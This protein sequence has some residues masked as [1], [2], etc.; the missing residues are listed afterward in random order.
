MISGTL[1]VFCTATGT[2]PLSM[3]LHSSSSVHRNKEN[4][5]INQT[6]NWGVGWG[7]SRCCQQAGGEHQKGLKH[8]IIKQII[9]QVLRGWLHPEALAAADK[10]ASPFFMFLGFS[11]LGSL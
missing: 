7:G 4:R 10:T 11:G 3:W 2:I 5:C 6:S 8:S 9:H 1:T